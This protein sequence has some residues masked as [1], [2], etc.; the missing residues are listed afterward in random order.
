MKTLLV[1]V[2]ASLGGALAVVACS[3]DSPGHADA[4]TCDCPAAEAPITASRIHRVEEAGTA[5]SNGYTTPTATCP[6]GELF[7]SGSCY[8]DQDNTAREV[9][10]VTAGATPTGATTEARS[11][12]CVFLNTS[13]TA[14]AEVRAQAMCLRP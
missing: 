8:I 9:S 5:A 10:V 2:A 12:Q 4:A 11:W 3:D 14:T 7:L 6:S 13:P 1:V